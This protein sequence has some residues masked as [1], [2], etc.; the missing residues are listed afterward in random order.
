MSRYAVY[1]YRNPHSL[2]YGFLYKSIC[3]RC[4]AQCRVGRHCPVRAANHR[5]PRDQGLRRRH[6]HSRGAA[7][8][9][10][11][12]ALP[13]RRA[14]ALDTEKYGCL[15]AHVH[16]DGVDGPLS[17]WMLAHGLAVPYDGGHKAEFATG[18]GAMR[19]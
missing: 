2:L 18:A 10:F 5:W 16:V 3:A 8:D 7:A 1:L 15:L 6:N 13:V 11:V 12:P 19:I 14:P 9:R 17:D 4:C